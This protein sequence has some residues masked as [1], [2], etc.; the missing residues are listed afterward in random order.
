[1]EY[2]N[3]DNGRGNW[4]QTV[5]GRR[6][7]P[8]DPRPEEVYIEDIA[9]GLSKMCRYNGQCNDFYSV[10]EH[11]VLVSH[12]VPR[13]HALQAL[14][15]DATEAYIAD[16]IRPVK[17]HLGGYKELEERNWFAIADRFGVAREFDPSVKQ[18]DNDVLLAEKAVLM[19]ANLGEWDVSG[20]PA[21]VRIL[22]LDHRS[23]RT[24]FLFRFHE[25]TLDRAED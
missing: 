16:I 14:L 22:C 13:E 17:C 12:C 11:S 4:M 2:N 15:H 18:A 6:Y 9:S 25:L 20:N 19:P 23:A 10:A 5:S 3:A 21:S 1:M 24:M 8:L 7:Y